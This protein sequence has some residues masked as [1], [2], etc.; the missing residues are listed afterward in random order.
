MEKVQ[1]QAFEVIHELK[2]KIVRYE[3]DLEKYTCL[4][5]EKTWLLKM[6]SYFMPKGSQPWDPPKFYILHHQITQKPNYD[7]NLQLRTIHP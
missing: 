2:E 1:K 7:S 3:Q 5:E 6:F 4:F